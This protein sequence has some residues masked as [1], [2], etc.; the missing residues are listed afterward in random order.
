M[1]TAEG[2]SLLSGFETRQEEQATW[3]TGGW[4]VEQDL[5]V[6]CSSLPLG[7]WTIILQRTEVV[8]G[9][10]I[11]LGWAWNPTS[12]IHP[13]PRTLPAPAEPPTAAKC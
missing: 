1:Q 4:V 6:S 5:L 3:R 13:P 12:M 2:R 9:K 8:D 7:F 11:Q 10:G